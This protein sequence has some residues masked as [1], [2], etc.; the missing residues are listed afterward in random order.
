VD[1]SKPLRAY[2][3]EVVMISLALILL[4]GS[5]AAWVGR[6]ASRRAAE[7]AERADRPARLLG[8]AAGFLGPGRAE[9][10]RAMAAEL[11]QVHGRRARWRFALGCAGGTML[12]PPRRGESGRVV[13]VLVTAGA[14]GCVGLVCYGLARYPGIVTGPRTWL[15]L[16]VF[17][18]V[19]A[20][21]ALAVATL[22]RRG[23]ASFGL[24][25]GLAVAAAWIIAGGLALSRGDAEPAFFWFLAVLPLAPLA[26]GAAAARRGRTGT[27]GRGGV[28]ISAV[29]ASLALFAVLAA[30]ALITAR[31][32]YDPG[33]VRDF[34]GSGMPS[35][36]AYAVSDNLGT[37][38]AL[39]LLTFTMTAVLGCTAATVAARVLRTTPAR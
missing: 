24:A 12:V 28:L 30:R 36:A 27:E 10:G 4:L 17:A 38:M 6:L 32:P 5:L 34:H 2:P 21:F 16:A 3:K 22:A 23:P 18:A 9:W 7:T 14:A 15:I 19:L 20:G 26:A 31:G 13:I 35:L 11:A 33:Q 37:A 29:V 8:W 25:A 39:M 1:A